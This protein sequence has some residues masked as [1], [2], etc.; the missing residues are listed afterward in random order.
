MMY[1]IVWKVY[2]YV[3]GT[4]KLY[5]IFYSCIFLSSL[6][7]TFYN[8]SRLPIAPAAIPAPPE[9]YRSLSILF[10]SNLS[11]GGGKS[12]PAKRKTKKKQEAR[13]KTK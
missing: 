12:V 13:K 2:M 8:L 10:G 7:G 1:E 5:T 11:L 3:C 9:L 6:P 4:L